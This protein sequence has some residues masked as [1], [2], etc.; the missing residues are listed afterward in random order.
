MVFCSDGII[1]AGNGEE[2]M[3]GFERTAE[4]IKRGCEQNLTAPQLLDDLISEVKTFAG[5]RVKLQRSCWGRS[6]G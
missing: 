1:E 3:F 5:A 6:G 4:T 2:K